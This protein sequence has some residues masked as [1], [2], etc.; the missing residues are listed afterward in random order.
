MTKTVLHIGANKTASTTL[1]RLLFA[2]HEKLHYLGEDGPGYI[3]YRDLVDSMV[4]DDDLYFPHAECTAFFATQ[5]ERALGKTLLYSNEDIMTSRVPLACARR[6]HEFLPGA[7]VLLVT[8]NQVTAVPSF[9]ASHGAYLKPAP[10]GYFRRHVSFDDWM[11]YCIMFIKYSPLAS[12][13]Y[14]RILKIYAELFGKESVH[15]LLYEEFVADKRNFMD[16]LSAILGIEAGTA[17]QMIDGGHERTRHTA[18]MLSY[19]RFRSRFLWNVPLSHYIP[20]G[21][22]VRESMQRYLESGPPAEGFM[23]DEWRNRISALY[24]EDNAE[25]ARNFRVPLASY[26]Y[27]MKAG[28]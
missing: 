17:L 6:L 2:R 24:A 25:L 9:Y 26:G 7:E 1:Q 12:Y 8:R 23:S 20:G 3:E 19:N 21:A 10:P 5:H 18:R 14:N 28:T 22:R 15:V 27:P 16:R 11:N 13:F 4:S